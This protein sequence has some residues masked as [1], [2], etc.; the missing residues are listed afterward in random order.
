MRQLE[1]G[2]AVSAGMPVFELADTSQLEIAT[3]VPE[4]DLAHVRPGDTAQ[5]SFPAAPG[6]EASAAVASIAPNAQ[7]ATRGFPV[8]LRLPE[9]AGGVVPGMIAL[10][11]FAYMK[12][13]G[14]MRIPARAVIDGHVFTVQDGKAVQKPIEVLLDEGEQ[15]YV[16]GLISTDQLI[17]NGQHYVEDGGAV[18]IV[19]SLGIGEI[20]RLEAD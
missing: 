1:A 19:D 12:S 3:E 2:Q 9:D 8:V 4:S 18:H 11:E 5:I 20:S 6:A 10:V 7:Q 17:I 15:L 13:P 16:D 14:G